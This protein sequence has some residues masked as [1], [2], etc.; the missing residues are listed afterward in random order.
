[1]PWFAGD[2]WFY[3]ALRVSGE[4]TPK[5]L[6]ERRLHLGIVHPRGA[7]QIERPFGCVGPSRAVEARNRGAAGDRPERLP[8]LRA[9]APR[10][11]RRRRIASAPTTPASTL[12]QMRVASS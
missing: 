10:T 3:A 11:R 1:M 2:V 6:T 5:P 8:T 12:G 4:Q 9:Y 7:V